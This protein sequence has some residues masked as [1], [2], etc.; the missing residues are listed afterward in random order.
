MRD[1]VKKHKDSCK[2]HQQPFWALPTEEIDSGKSG[3]EGYG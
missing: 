3:V 1:F 2:F